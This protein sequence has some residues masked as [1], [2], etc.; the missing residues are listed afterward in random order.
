MNSLVVMTLLVA[1]IV[2][3]RG[4]GIDYVQSRYW[5]AKMCH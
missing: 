3:Q 4:I 5:I 1:S 2:P